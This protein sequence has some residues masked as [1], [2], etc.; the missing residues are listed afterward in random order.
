MDVLF[1]AMPAACVQP[2]T[3]T[4][5]TLVLHLKDDDDVAKVVPLMH[6]RWRLPVPC[7]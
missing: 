7:E 6:V 1:N 5:L 2:N 3:N 4:F